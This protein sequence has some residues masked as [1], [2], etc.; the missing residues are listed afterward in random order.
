[1]RAT[2]KLP[3]RIVLVCLTL[4]A[5]LCISLSL[6][7]QA[8]AVGS[9][10]LTPEETR[11]KEIYLRGTA[12]S[13]N[14]ILAYV[15]DAAIEVP[16]SAMPCANC[17]GADGKGK[18]EGGVV[19]SNLTWEALTKPY[20]VTHANGRKHPAY[21]ERGL[22]LAILRGLDPAGNK[23]LSVMPR[24]QMPPGDLADLIAYLKRVGEEHVRGVSE[25]GIVV[26]TVVPAVGTLAPMGEAVRAVTTAYF[27]EINNQGGIYNRKI[28]LKFVETAS[29]PTATATNL[30]R[31]IQ[32][33][34]IFAL[35]GAFTAGAD[36]E[37]AAVVKEL[38]VPLVGP[39]TL[40]PELG[41]RVNRYVFY[42]LPGMDVQARA[43]VNY[44][45]QKT[46]LQKTGA[47]IVYPSEGASS[48]SILKAIND[49]CQKKGCAAAETFSYQRQSFDAAA[50]AGQ[51]IATK[52]N[53]LF[54]LGTSS[55][56]LAL[57]KQADKEGWAP[58]IFLAGTASGNE[59]FE[60]PSS[61]KQKL[62]FALPA[63]PA[64]QTAEGI[65]EFRALAA[66]YK[67][68][69]NHI[70]SQLLAY[71]AARLLVEGIKRSGKDLSVEN[72]VGSLEGIEQFSTGLIPPVSFGPN[73]RLGAMGAYIVSVDLEQKTLQP[74]SP[75]IKVD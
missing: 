19:P 47:L 28:N 68:P 42:V 2:Y 23:L 52:K 11:G 10:G 13:G 3:I 7:T 17:H 59:L 4:L 51:L 57:M 44:A 20:G 5:A 6:R 37:L 41:D 38:E 67:V 36:T 55:E 25:N 73:R 12:T 27:E 45:V 60:S 15:G 58:Y 62:F 54:F 48:G 21:T 69:P 29:T 61:F 1:L 8:A 34:Q 63:S 22:E 43:L 71:S 40:Q 66:K 18:P 14:E 9:D 30:R 16:G 46:L 31:F 39:L 50:L 32:D 49:Q 24:Y 53:V 35:T 56:A 33:Q 64:D 75:W 26:G 70:A 72:L 65:G 74:A